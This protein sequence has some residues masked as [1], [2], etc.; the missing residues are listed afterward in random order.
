MFIAHYSSNYMYVQSYYGTKVTYYLQ[1]LCSS[2]IQLCFCEGILKT[3]FSI[4]FNITANQDI[5]DLYELAYYKT[6]CQKK[7]KFIFKF[8]KMQSFSVYGKYIPTGHTILFPA[9]TWSDKLYS[10]V[11]H[12]QPSYS[13]SPSYFTVVVIYLYT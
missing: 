7:L 11:Y 2:S 12:P 13:I 4:F 8:L 1:N 10:L 6:F 9:K 3:Y 5:N